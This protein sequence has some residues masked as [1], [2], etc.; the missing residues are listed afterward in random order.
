MQ[1]AEDSPLFNGIINFLEQFPNLGD[2]KIS[3]TLG[4][5]NKIGGNIILNYLN[6]GEIAK[7]LIDCA[8]KNF[9]PFIK[10]K[11]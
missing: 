2:E 3:K 1:A 7:I 6:E 8:E 9:A 5:L 11:G 10:A 4:H